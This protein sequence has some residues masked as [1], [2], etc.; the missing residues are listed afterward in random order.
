MKE[1]KCIA[2]VFEPLKLVTVRTACEHH[3]GDRVEEDGNDTQDDQR[4]MLTTF[5]TNHGT[6]ASFTSIETA[7]K[8]AQRMR[9]HLVDF[10]EGWKMLEK[11]SDKY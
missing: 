10:L 9:V 3:V 7:S 4:A 8:T 2:H 1:R 11:G 6:W 5:P